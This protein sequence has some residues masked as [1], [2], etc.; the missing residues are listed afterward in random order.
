MNSGRVIALGFF[1]GVHLGHASLLNMAKLRAK[2]LNLSPAVMSF[3]LHPDALVA[4][5]DVTLINSVEDRVE[6]LSRCYGIDD[7]ILC[8]FDR[9][10]MHM[11][12]DVFLEDFLVRQHGARHLVCGYDF[13]FGD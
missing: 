12:W 10:M 5:A 4:G 13:R 3:D 9:A 8:H 7:V 11:P 6:I 2:E 1:D